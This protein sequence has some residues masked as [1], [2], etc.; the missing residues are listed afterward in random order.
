[1]IA[2]REDRWD[3]AEALHRRALAILE[4]SYGAEHPRLVS[5]LNNLGVTYWHLGRYRDAEPYY[6]RSLAI[7]ESALGHD[8]PRVGYPLANLGLVLW[9]LGDLAT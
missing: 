1:M 5:V 7:R 8:N 4:A 2:R 3:E 9:K 6:R